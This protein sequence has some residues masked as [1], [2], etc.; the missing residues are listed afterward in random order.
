MS[1]GFGGRLTKSFPSQV[2][3]DVT[4]VCNL[5]CIHCPHEALTKTEHYG[6]FFLS[7]ALSRKAVDEVREHG[8]Q[9]M[10]YCAEGEPLVHP[11][12]YDMLDYAVAES[13]TFVTLTTNGTTMDDRRMQRLL[14]SGIHMIDV[15]LDAYH[16][17]TYKKIRRADLE[18][19]RSN[20]ARL[21]EIA[22]GT[23]TKIVVSFIEQEHNRDEV[24]A[25]QDFWLG[26]GAIPVVRK[27]HTAAGAIRGPAPIASRKPCVYP[28][29]RIVVGPNGKLNFCP[30]EWFGGAVVA[31][32]RETTIKEVWSGAFYDGLRD[33]HLK[34]KC[35]GLCKNCPD[36]QQTRW[37]GEGRAYADLVAEL[38]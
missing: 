23:G 19:P 8:S 25:F 6:P 36:W 1:Y 34:N 29:E 5:D 37:P 27:L 7:D 14:K 13:G 12:I 18:I 16:A 30:Q 26:L 11:G 38:S 35:F 17:E 15:S 22:K 24:G 28:W 2:I 33:A 32:Y 20:T 10:R 4:D 31:D 3:V 9:Y 21:A